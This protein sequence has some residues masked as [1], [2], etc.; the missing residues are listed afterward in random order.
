MTVTTVDK[1]FE[2]AT[3]RLSAEYPASPERVWQLWADPR[4]LERWWG[5]PTHPATVTDH[6]LSAGGTVRYYMSGPDGEKYH[7]GWRVITAEA[8]HRIEVEDFFADD[9][10]NEVTDM[11]LSRMIVSIQDIG[12]GRTRMNLETRYASA[13][14]MTKVL[15]MGMEEGITQALGQIDTLLAEQPG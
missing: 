12:S 8:P 4:Q 11:P 6:D 15:D 3:L 10:G 13:E 7:G 1:D 2:A 14:A 9:E 5:P